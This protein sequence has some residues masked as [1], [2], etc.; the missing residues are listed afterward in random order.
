LTARYRRLEF[1]D[2]EL[3]PKHGPAFGI[4]NASNLKRTLEHP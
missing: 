2:V 4:Q 3:T 1:C